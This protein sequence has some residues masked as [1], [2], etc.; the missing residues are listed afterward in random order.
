[1]EKKITKKYDNGEVT[2]VW[3]PHICV[4]SKVCFQGL[5]EVFD[6]RKKPWVSV[7][8]ADTE[9]IVNQVTKC[10]SGALSYIVNGEESSEVEV[11][12]ETVVEVTTNGP[13]LLFGNLIIK[14]QDG[15]EQK[16]SKVTALCRCG[17]SG[18]KPFCDGTH[19]KVSFQG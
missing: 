13:L 10:P 4:H 14:D 11:S 19:V 17:H 7:E 15:N 9:T 5:P 6:P 16:K 8:G 2:V 1:M 12:K 18:N 3:Q